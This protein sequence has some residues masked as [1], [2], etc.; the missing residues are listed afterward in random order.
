MP[1][2]SLGAYWD[3]SII[4]LSIAFIKPSYNAP[5]LIR[6]ILRSVNNFIVNCFDRAIYNAPHV[7]IT[8]RDFAHKAGKERRLDR[9]ALHG[10]YCSWLSPVRPTKTAGMYFCHLLS[11]SYKRLKES[12]KKRSLLS[13]VVDSWQYQYAISLLFA[14]LGLWYCSYLG[15]ESR[16]SGLIHKEESILTRASKGFTADI[17]DRELDLAYQWIFRL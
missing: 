8:V 3:L 9:L 12:I 14:G 15:I 11:M 5:D 10:Q 6:I 2:I 7:N 17:V 16:L 1:W 13:H 4:L